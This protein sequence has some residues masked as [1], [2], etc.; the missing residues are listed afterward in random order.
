MPLQPVQTKT[1][2]LF[3]SQYLF[4]NFYS[5]CNTLNS[6]VQTEHQTSTF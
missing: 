1:H 5:I 2:C 6:S 4:F 3:L